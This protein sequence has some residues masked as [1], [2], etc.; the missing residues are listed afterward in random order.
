MLVHTLL[1]RRAF[2]LVELMIV[3]A[4]MGVIGAFA[5]PAYSDYIVRTK[6]SGMLSATDVIKTAVSEY[7]GVN[8]NLTEIDPTDAEATFTALGVEDPSELSDAISEVKFTKLNDNAMSIVVCGSTAGQGTQTADTV[9][10]Y[11]TGEYISSG[12]KW[13]CAYTG[14]SKFVPKSCRTLYVPADFGAL[15]AA[16]ARS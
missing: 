4:I 12:M 8:G 5:V 14:N 3:I 16:C 6:V 7:R 9:D 2:S 10:I 1:W 15:N 11:L 13:A